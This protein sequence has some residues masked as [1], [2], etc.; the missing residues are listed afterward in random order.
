MVGDIC[1]PQR[2]RGKTHDCKSFLGNALRKWSGAYLRCRLELTVKAPG[3]VELSRQAFREGLGPPWGHD[4]RLP[5][6]ML[7]WSC[8]SGS[9]SL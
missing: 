3:R 8:L 2:D 5:E 6:A 1:T 7:V 4:L 9:D